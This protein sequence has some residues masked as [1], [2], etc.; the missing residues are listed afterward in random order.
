MIGE[1]ETTPF[2]CEDFLT[3]YNQGREMTAAGK[4]LDAPQHYQAAPN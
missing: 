2:L 4:P 3:I 1:L